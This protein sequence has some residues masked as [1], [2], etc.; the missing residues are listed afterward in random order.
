MKKI[1]AICFMLS[2]QPTCEMVST[3]LC[4]HKQLNIR[5]F[6]LKRGTG[7]ICR[8]QSS[9]LPLPSHSLATY[10]QIVSYIDLATR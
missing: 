1:C 9:K 4:I 6:G 10:I 3:I 7:V 5:H 2:D 8:E